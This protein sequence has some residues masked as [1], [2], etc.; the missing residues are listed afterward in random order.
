MNADSI[1]AV[2]LLRFSA[3]YGLVEQREVD[4]W[5]GTILTQE[6]A[7]EGNQNGMK[8]QYALAGH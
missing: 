6:L 1:L 8:H 7:K 4:R 2:R 5:V 3:A